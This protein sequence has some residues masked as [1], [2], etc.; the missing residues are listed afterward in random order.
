MTLEAKKISIV[1][2]IL[3]LNN[4]AVVDQISA[5]VNDIKERG[6]HPPGVSIVSYSQLK[7][8]KFDLDALKTEQNYR[9]FAEGEL[10]ALIEEADVQESIEELLEA[11]D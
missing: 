6:V 11:L 8:R 2:W 5:S 9:P 4:E 10:D 1:Q 7:S 3:G